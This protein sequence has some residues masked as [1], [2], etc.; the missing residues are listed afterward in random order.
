MELFILAF[1]GVLF[2]TVSVF[3]MKKIMFMLVDNEI[4]FLQSLG[5][6]GA[7]LVLFILFFALPVIFKIIIIVLVGGFN[8]VLEPIKNFI[9]KEEN[10]AFYMRKIM[11]C[12]RLLLENPYAWGTMSQK[13]YYYFKIKD[14]EKA[15]EIQSKV[16]SMS[17]NDMEESKKLKV[18][19]KYYDKLFDTDVRCW[20]C[21]RMVPRGVPSCGF[22]G[23]SMNFGENIAEW[24]KK[25]GYKEII[26]NVAGLFLIVF[27]YKFLL[28]YL[29]ENVRF[30]IHILTA[31][32]IGICIVYCRF[33]KED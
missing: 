23:H 4:T 1:W 15:I 2:L 22:C 27:L 29:S 24:L 7:Y 17:K 16:V 13:A 20:Y 18:Y 9:N 3:Y 26:V 25:G 28:G 14:Y 31:V 11:E 12:D 8:F 30:V 5:Y 21:G 33:T 6:F 10:N 32:I 19:Q